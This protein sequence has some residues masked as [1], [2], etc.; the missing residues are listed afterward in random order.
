MPSVMRDD[1]FRRS[2]RVD[3]YAPI[4]DYAVIG[5]GR[6][7]AL[8]ALDG[9]IDWL[10][11][12]DFDSG[13]V[14]GRILDAERGGAFTLAPEEPFE[15]AHRYL[16]ESNVLET[17]FRTAGGTVRVTDALTLADSEAL[18]PA[19]ELVRRVEGLSGSVGLRWRLEPRFEFGTRQPK[20]GHRA[21]RPV[22][23]GGRE[24]L[25][26]SAWEAGDAD[27]REGGFEASFIAGNGDAATLT[28]TA[29]HDEP[30]VLPSR[31]DAERRLEHTDR[32]W[33]TWASKRTYDGPW[34]EHV[35]RSAL[36][37]KL[38]VY[39]PSGAVVAAPTTSL[40]EWIGGPRN[41]DYRFTWIRDAAYT[42]SALLRLG[43]P[44]EAQAFL[45]WAAHATALTNPELRVVYTLNGSLRKDELELPLAGYRRSRPVRVGNAA[46]RQTQLDMYG[47]MLDC[48][49]LYA[50]EMGELDA[51]KGRA[52]AAIAD[53]VGEHW[54]ERDAGIWEARTDPQHYV[55]SKWMCWVALDRACRLA[56]LGVIPD[57]T[58]KWRS[59]A[60]DVRSWLDE[61]GWDAERET[62]VRCEGSEEVDGSL[63]TLAL[64]ACDDGHGGRRLRATV[65]AVRRELADGPLVRRYRAEESLHGPEGAFLP[66]S[67]WLAEALAKTGRLDEAAVLMDDLVALSSDVGLYS[68]ERGPDGTFLGN[69]PQALVHLAL[70]N[71]AITIDEQQRR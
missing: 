12:P 17:I 31:D 10:C 29:A 50:D 69:F 63:L 14:F 13:S 56:E 19:R 48:V 38:L 39:A 27:E 62:F 1:T 66:C 60:G 40:P 33:R 57:R 71:A 30:L 65:D 58:E 8:V 46:V 26:L 49:W 61:H 64:F 18:P 3:G 37:L 34:R 35:L 55:Q 11:L 45:W 24:A 9:S 22:L 59:A 7:A 41:W 25:A 4:R 68:E 23:L 6:T 20:R 28:L 36:V 70:V 5:A 47:A 51:A 42:M 44:A 43:C 52:I 2:E 15:A 54:G 16:D 67:F 21:G 32:F 53:W